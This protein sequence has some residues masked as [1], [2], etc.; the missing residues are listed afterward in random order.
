MQPTLRPHKST[1]KPFA[2]VTMSVAGYLFIVCVVVGGIW[3]STAEKE[4]FDFVNP[5]FNQF[6]N[7]IELSGGRPMQCS[8][9]MHCSS[10]IEHE[11]EVLEIDSQTRKAS[12]IPFTFSPTANCTHDEVF[13]MFTSC[14]YVYFCYSRNNAIDCPPCG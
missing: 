2:V 14:S 5:Y 6:Y 12:I 8:S 4:A 13:L 9:S 1:N 11:K 10:K 3:Q 7:T